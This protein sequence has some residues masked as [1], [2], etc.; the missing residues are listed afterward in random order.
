MRVVLFSIAFVFGVLVGSRVDLPGLPFLGLALL[1]IPFL[2]LLRRHGAVLVLITLTALFMGVSRG[3]LDGS[4]PDRS[5]LSHYNGLG[6]VQVLGTVATYPEPRE[7]LTQFRFDAA[8]M[9]FQ[10]MPHKVSGSVLVRARPAL[11]MVR[12]R[13]PPY[14]RYGD[15]L[16]LTGTLQDPPRLADFDWRDHLARQGIHSLIVLPQVEFID[17]SGGIAPL[18]A[19]Y[20]IRAN[21]ASNLAHALSQPQASLSQAML[22]GLR[23]TLPSQLREDLKKTGTTHLIAIS[24]LHVGVVIGMVTT[25]SIA[26]LGRRR[27]LYVLIPLVAIWGYAL[28]TGLAP[29]V[30]RAAIMGSLYLISL[31]L[32]R[33]RSAMVAISAA[34]AIMVAVDPDVL[35]QLSFQLSFLAMVGLIFLAPWFQVLGRRLVSRLEGRERWSY[36]TALVISDITAISLGAI[37]ATAPL[38]FFNF[39]SI[40]LVGLPA[41]LLALPALPPIL[42]T[43]ILVA[44]AGLFSSTLALA[45]AW[46]AWPW[47]TYMMGV[48]ELFSWFPSLFWD[49]GDAAIPLVWA[50]Y[51]V[52]V[53]VLVLL[54]RRFGVP[55]SGV[56]PFFPLSWRSV[57]SD[58]LTRAGLA[59]RLGVCTTIV[60]PILLVSIT[61]TQTPDRLRVTFLD[62]GQGDSVLIQTPSQQTVLVD[63]GPDPS[64]LALEMG[65][66]LPFWEKVLDLVVLTHPDG[67]H[68]D[69]LLWLTQ[70]YDVGQV[71]ECGMDCAG[72][73]NV[74][75]YLRWHSLV[76]REGWSVLD[77]Q[78]G[79]QIDLGNGVSISVLHPP[80]EPLG[81]T[82]SDTNNNSVVMKLTYGEIDFLLTADIEGFAEGYLL[83]NDHDL[84]ATILKVAHHG[85][86]SSITPQFLQA[87]SPAF[88]VISVGA[89]NI[90]GH[91]HPQT[92]QTLSEKMPQE[93]ILLTSQLGSIQFETDGHRLWLKTDH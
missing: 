39:H 67:D 59:W 74:R 80:S 42:L 63:G 18:S 65:Q 21:M 12:L 34:A 26:L 29:P 6:E 73:F 35:E 50:Y 68:L 4:V 49:A 2:L 7:A 46:L 23:S 30:Y 1:L 82:G 32:G 66:R 27:H 36:A 52:M 61:L 20:D 45:L 60:L 10:G 8:E 13:D 38:I 48:V 76:E 11:E 40:S 22:L 43:S 57:P 24:G 28:L 37:L 91:P 15:A 54:H 58:H 88:A 86:K 71:I 62:V 78:A 47:I 56:G 77:A 19:M 25:F 70:R 5:D 55:I 83:R 72:E 17:D 9:I 41:T 92:I 85:S 87:V 16:R 93:R 69:G 84:S 3:A 33:P 44:V 64:V 51:G 89:D 81:G 14:I 31:L 79:Q 75:N 90:Y 53:L